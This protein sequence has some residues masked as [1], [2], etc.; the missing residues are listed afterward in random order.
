[1]ILA[2]DECN[3]MG[4]EGNPGFFV[5]VSAPRAAKDVIITSG[6]L[7]GPVR[8][9]KWHP[10]PFWDHRHVLLTPRQ[11]REIGPRHTS[12]IAIPTLV[13]YFVSRGTTIHS[14]LLLDGVPHEPTRRGLESAIASVAPWLEVEYHIGGDKTSEPIAEADRIAYLL[15]DRYRCGEYE[16]YHRASRLK[17]SIEKFRKFIPER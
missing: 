2:H 16:K 10:N 17:P 12:I 7:R 5:V 6:K 14:P 3:F 8:S 1:M 15:F 11:I 4:N 13:S 9:R